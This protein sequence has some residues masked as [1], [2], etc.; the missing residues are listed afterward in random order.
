MQTL[1]P[2]LGSLALMGIVAGYTNMMTVVWLQTRM[3]RAYLGRVMG[4]LL[5]AAVGFIPVSQVVADLL[6]GIHLSLLFAVAGSLI[7]ISGLLF[8]ASQGARDMD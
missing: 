3:D 8:G 2:I 1:L 4:L 5:F 7:V 6:A